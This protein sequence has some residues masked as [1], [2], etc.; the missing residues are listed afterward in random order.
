MMGRPGKI[1]QSRASVAALFAAI[2][3]A[4]ALGGGCVASDGGANDDETT[5]QQTPDGGSSSANGGSAG[6]D[7]PSAG[8]GEEGSAGAADGE[9]EESG[10]S[11]APPPSAGGGGTAAPGGAGGGGAGGAAAISDPAATP[12]PPSSG[13]A[14]GTMAATGGTGGTA[15]VVDGGVAPPPAPAAGSGGAAGAP[16]ASG[17][18]YDVETSGDPVDTGEEGPEAPPPIPPGQLTAAE[19]NDLENW[20]FFRGLMETTDQEGDSWGHMQEHWGFDT[21]SRVTVRVEHESQPVVGAYVILTDDQQ[22]VLWQARTDVEGRAELFVG[23]FA[24]TDSDAVTLSV[25]HGDQS[26]E[27][28]IAA[29]EM[30]SSYLIELD[31]AEQ[32]ALA[33]DLMFMVDTTGS[34][35]DELSYIQSEL[36]DVIS[37]VEDQV[38]QQLDTRL[39]VNFYRDIG[40]EYVVR[41]FPFTEDISEAVDQLRAQGADGGGDYEEAVDQAIQSAVEEHSWS[42][43]ATTRLMFLVLDAPPHHTAQIIDSIHQS[44]EQAAAAGIQIIPV[45]ASGIDKPTEFLLRFL[46]IA[47]N[48]TYVF[49][50]D[51]S[52]IGGSHLPA[53]PTIGP[54]EIELLNDLLVRIII[55]RLG[56]EGS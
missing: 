3:L 32:A 2:F 46:A 23:M 34:M 44:V 1:R 47:T 37:R 11:E 48:G 13:G 21:A 16:G 7:T 39:S 40:D 22:E 24:S 43:E 33:L 17:G 4:S 45:S 55:E 29:D 51:H 49:I 6:G 56:F 27:Q 19:W 42:A 53:E 36:E 14:G 15:A 38:A 41:A 8:D 12:T 35:S 25:E 5:G 52:G 20:D 26:S 30:E 10:P 54:H 28:T 9:G 31:S 50:T 18:D